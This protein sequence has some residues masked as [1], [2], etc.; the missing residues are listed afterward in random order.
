M[1]ADPPRSKRAQVE[2]IDV[3]AALVADF[4]RYGRGTGPVRVRLLASHQGLWAV[5]DYRF[6]HRVRTRRRVPRSLHV[7]SFILQ[8][9]GGHHGHLDH[10][11]RPDRPGLY[12]GHFGGIFVGRDVVMGPGCTLSQGVTVG[13]SV[14]GEDRGS[15]VVGAGLYFAPGVKAFGPIS[16]GAGTQIGA[17][18]V[19]QP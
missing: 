4:G 9:G 19:V 13:E 17:N 1:P 8:V 11:D 16:I 18:A 7:L 14:S 3:R 2:E 12:V 15:P 5:V 6:R 10:G